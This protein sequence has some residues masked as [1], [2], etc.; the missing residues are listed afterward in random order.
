MI[1]STLFRYWNQNSKLRYLAVGF[2]NTLFSIFILYSLFFLF[3]DRYYLYELGANFIISTTQSYFTQRFF[4]WKSKN[5]YKKEFI[6]FILVSFLQYFLNSSLIFFAV[7]FF[8]LRA[9]AVALP[10]A[11]MLV[12]LFYLI[13]QRT[14]F[15]KY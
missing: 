15:S 11:L 9:S 7:N 5:P 1:K 4:V 10:I 6:K 14:V 8:K 2:W 12:C 13:N 3:S